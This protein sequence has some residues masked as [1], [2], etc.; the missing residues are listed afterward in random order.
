MPVSNAPLEFKTLVRHVPAHASA[1]RD[2]VVAFMDRDML[3]RAL[4]QADPKDAIGVAMAYLLHAVDTNAVELRRTL[5]L[6][7]SK[8]GIPSGSIIEVLNR[9]SK[10]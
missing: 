5:H 6:H 3:A 1:P 9:V 2:E 10:G 4:L 8:P 7:I